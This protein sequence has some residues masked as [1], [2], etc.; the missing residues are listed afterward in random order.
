MR[1]AAVASRVGAEQGMGEEKRGVS[2]G[3]RS[4]VVLK[5]RVMLVVVVT[6]VV[7]L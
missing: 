2:V 6:R 1:V 5:V 7:M 4:C 3:G